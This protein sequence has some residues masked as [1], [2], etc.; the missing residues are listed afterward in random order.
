MLKVLK[1]LK[2]GGT[3]ACNIDRL[4]SEWAKE[5]YSKGLN[6]TLQEYNVLLSHISSRIKSPTGKQW[7]EFGEQVFNSCTI[8]NMADQTTFKNYFELMLR[9]KSLRRGDAIEQ[10]L[11]DHSIKVTPELLIRLIKGYLL[12]KNFQRAIELFDDHYYKPGFLTFEFYEEL[13]LNLAKSEK[14]SN[15][16]VRELYYKILKSDIKLTEN[17]ENGFLRC[18]ERLDSTEM[19]WLFTKNQ[20]TIQ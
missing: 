6:P 19:T 17:M 3:K 1:D 20:D 8:R 13:I 2:V 11:K 15:Y 14:G 16:A 5:V 4:R 7:L 10:V 12:D 9:S 18:C